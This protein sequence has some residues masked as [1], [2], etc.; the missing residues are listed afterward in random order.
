MDDNQESIKKLVMAFLQSFYGSPSLTQPVPV[1]I[2]DELPAIET[3]PVC[4]DA[5]GRLTTC[6]GRGRRKKKKKNKR[7][8]KKAVSLKALTCFEA[9]V[10]GGKVHRSRAPSLNFWQLQTFC[11]F[12]LVLELS[13]LTCFSL[14]C[15]VRRALQHGEDNPPKVDAGS[16]TLIQD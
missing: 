7:K 3:I 10:Y 12:Q 4:G 15:P 14:I 1:S 2:V 6:E 11:K 13:W 16:L 9:L 8:A 5:Q